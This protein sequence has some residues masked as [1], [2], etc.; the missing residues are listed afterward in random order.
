MIQILTVRKPLNI[1]SPRF[2]PVEDEHSRRDH[3]QS[4]WLAVG[5][6][7]HAALRPHLVSVSACFSTTL[8][9]GIKPVHRMIG[10]WHL[11]SQMP[12]T[13]GHMAS[14]HFSYPCFLSVLMNLGD[15]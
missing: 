9:L 8:L 14:A 10:A 5:E 1:S 2:I 11:N 6:S 15:A 13:L 12:L 3:F 7:R 4:L